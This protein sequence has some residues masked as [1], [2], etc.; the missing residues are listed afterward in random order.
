MTTYINANTVPVWVPTDEEDD[1][2]GNVVQ[3]MKRV[4]PGDTVD[5]DDHVQ[6]AGVVPEDS[7]DHDAIVEARE[8]ISGP[9]EKA[10]PLTDEDLKGGTVTTDKDPSTKRSSRKSSKK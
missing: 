7:V 10:Y 6:V 1:E 5:L 8:A 2:D 4:E 3:G 9:G